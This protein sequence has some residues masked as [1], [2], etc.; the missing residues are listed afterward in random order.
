MPLLSFYMVSE[1]ESLWLTS[2]DHT[3]TDWLELKRLLAEAMVK[4]HRERGLTE[5]FITLQR[6]LPGRAAALSIGYRPSLIPYKREFEVAFKARFSPRTGEVEIAQAS[7][8][9]TFSHVREDYWWMERGIRWKIPSVIP[10]E[11]QSALGNMKSLLMEPSAT[12]YADYSRKPKK[13][14]SFGEEGETG[15]YMQSREGIYVQMER[16]LSENR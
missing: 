11:H 15:P 3:P 14:Y 9:Y 5:A 1:R 2:V 8:N 6:H 7:F 10:R 13:I 4:L 12:R 16:R